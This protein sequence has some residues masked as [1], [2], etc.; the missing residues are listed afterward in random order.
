MYRLRGPPLVRMA[1]DVKM[2]PRPALWAGAT[3]REVLRWGNT[4][5]QL[6]PAVSVGLRGNAGSMQTRAACYEGTSPGKATMAN[7]IQYRGGV[8]GGGSNLVSMAMLSPAIPL[9]PFTIPPTTEVPIAEEAEVHEGTCPLTGSVSSDGA[10][11]RPG[12]Q[13]LL[14]WHWSST[15]PL[16]LLSEGPRPQPSWL[17]SRGHF[18]PCL[19]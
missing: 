19:P 14:W 3:P 2:H 16:Q 1:L 13:V 17:E 8:D 10:V 4:T 9:L 6:L 18:I 15:H 5:A 12:G 11:S 7:R